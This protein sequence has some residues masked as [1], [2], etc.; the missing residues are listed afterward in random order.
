MKILHNIASV[1]LYTL[2]SCQNDT[3]SRNYEKKT[4][5][6]HLNHIH[7][8]VK[9]KHHQFNGFATFKRVILVL[10]EKVQGGAIFSVFTTKLDVW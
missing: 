6:F 2:Q 1:V 8:L 5:T 10:Y 9:F 7:W 4:E 3:F